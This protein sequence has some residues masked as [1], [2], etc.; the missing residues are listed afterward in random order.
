M[1]LVSGQL[2]Q[3]DDRIWFQ[4]K[5]EKAGITFG[6]ALPRAILSP[7]GSVKLRQ[8]NG[9]ETDIV[10]VETPRTMAAIAIDGG[11]SAS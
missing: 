10:E 2:S 1:N 9:F 5:Q 6:M 11:E 4:A 7:G 8:K 3:R